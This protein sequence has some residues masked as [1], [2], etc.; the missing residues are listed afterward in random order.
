MRKRSQMARCHLQGPT[1]Y[2]GGRHSLELP[3]WEDRMASD[4]T[5]SAV[6]P[7]VS[8][9]ENTGGTPP[10]STAQ[11]RQQTVRLPAALDMRDLVALIVLIVLTA[12]DITGVQY[13][14]PAA[15]LY[16]TLGLLAFLLPC[17][18]VTQWLARRF[19][20]QGA[21]DLWASHIVGIGASLFGMWGTVTNSLTSTIS[22]SH[23]A[24]LVVVTTLTVLAVGVI[25][26]KV[27]G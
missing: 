12:S 4:T 13:M 10:A 27:L 8:L 25:C 16:W 17:A 3:A 22:D 15:F 21:C 1:I 2:R 5:F 24:A 14:G 9:S 18:F 20:R 7:T 11:E 6:V 23:W 19:G 26:S